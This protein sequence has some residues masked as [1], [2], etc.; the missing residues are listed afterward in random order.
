MKFLSRTAASTDSR[1]WRTLPGNVERQDNL[2]CSAGVVRLSLTTPS[3]S[4]GV[5]TRV[6]RRGGQRRRRCTGVLKPALK[7]RDKPRL[8]QIRFS[9]LANL[10][11]SRTNLACPAFA[12]APLKACKWLRRLGLGTCWHAQGPTPLIGTADSQ[13]RNLHLR[14]KGFGLKTLCLTGPK[15]ADLR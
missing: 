12:G 6:L 5:L 10:A 3:D 14:L 8:V 7:W 11:S 15:D 2:G 13:K 1:L 4:R 9:G